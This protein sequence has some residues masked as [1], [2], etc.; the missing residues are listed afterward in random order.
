MKGPPA[1]MEVVNGKREKA[2]AIG[3]Y[4][5][6]GHTTAL[7]RF[8][9]VGDRNDGEFYYIFNLHSGLA[10]EG[11]TLMNISGKD[12]KKYTYLCQDE[13]QSNDSA[14]M[15]EFVIPMTPVPVGWLQI[16]NV[17]TGHVLSH[18]YAY[19][20]PR[21][22]NQ[23]LPPV[24]TLNY[25]ETWDTQW[26]LIS[27]KGEYVLK[28]RLTGC[29]LTTEFETNG[30]NEEDRRGVTMMGGGS[31]LTIEL[32]A[33]RNWKIWDRKGNMLLGEA[34]ASTS[35]EGNLVVANSSVPDP[36]RSWRLVPMH[37]VDATMIAPEASTPPMYAAKTVRLT[38]SPSIVSEV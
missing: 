14:Q 13:H 7:W 5:A 2:T 33:Q 24:R 38:S 20:P 1:V 17:S 15:L 4:L 12:H 32:D 22:I 26:T 29:L 10:L 31:P 36:T 9:R 25:R 27:D 21:L 8:A 23:Q 28:N 19:S 16:K 37:E 3:R 11:G 18:T 34:P 6:H 30:P 35:V